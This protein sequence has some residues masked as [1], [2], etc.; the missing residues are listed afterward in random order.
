MLKGAGE[1]LDYIAVHTM[2]AQGPKNPKASIRSWACRQNP[3]G[4]W[5]EPREMSGQAGCSS[6][7]W[8]TRHGQRTGSA[9]D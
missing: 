9:S 8:K 1:H 7:K 3:E 6:C 5:E 4:A 2:G